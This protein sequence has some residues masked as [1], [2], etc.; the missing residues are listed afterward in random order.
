MCSTDP[1]ARGDVVFFVLTPGIVPGDPDSTAMLLV[2][3]D[4]EK[5]RDEVSFGLTNGSALG[6]HF[7]PQILLGCILFLKQ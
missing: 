6:L 1:L 7:E 4:S 3:P 5:P 2:G